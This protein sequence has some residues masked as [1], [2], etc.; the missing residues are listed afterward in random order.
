MGDTSNAGTGNTHNL[1][2]GAPD[3]NSAESIRLTALEK[4]AS[5]EICTNAKGEVQWS[6]KAYAVTPQEA[7]DLVIPVH[8]QLVRMKAHG[9]GQDGKQGI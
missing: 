6:I 5:V 7:A 4:Q 9:P 2:R 8:Q 1:P 3:P